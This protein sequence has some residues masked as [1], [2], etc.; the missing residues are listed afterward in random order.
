LE[1]HTRNS[2]DDELSLDAY[3]QDEYLELQSDASSSDSTT[4]ISNSSFD[5][6]ALIPNVITAVAS[7]CRSVEAK[8]THVEHKY[9]KTLEQ[10]R[11]HFAWASA[12]RVK[13]SLEASTQLYRATQWARKIKRHFKS[14]FP[15]ANV[16]RIKETVS[17]DTAYMDV[18]GRADGITGHGGAQGFQ[19][20]VVTSP[21]TRFK[22]MAISPKHSKTT[23]GCTEHH[24]SYSATTPRQKC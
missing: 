3:F 22:P 10:L 24:R 8:M 19:I 18:K 14:R 13:A 17:T 4:I 12:D 9:G 7:V 20:F 11:P 21:S 23:F 1:S 6:P 2:S 16:E 5:V 15:G